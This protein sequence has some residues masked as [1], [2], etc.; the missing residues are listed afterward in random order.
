MTNK[1]L[2]SLEERDPQGAIA[3]V[4]D[5]IRVSENRAA[6]ATRLAREHMNRAVYL[7]EVLGGMKARK[8]ARR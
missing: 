1:T 7:S 2:Q 6:A 5:E 4:A 8:A 3:F